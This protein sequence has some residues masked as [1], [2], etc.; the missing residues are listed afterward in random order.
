MYIYSYY[1]PAV[2]LAFVSY[3]VTYKGRYKLFKNEL[4]KTFFKNFFCSRW[5]DSVCLKLSKS[6][7]NNRVYV[8]VYAE[9]Q[10]IFGTVYCTLYSTRTECRQTVR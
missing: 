3:N 10:I 7:H 4:N 2:Y 6:P 5:I 1:S 8:T 9:V